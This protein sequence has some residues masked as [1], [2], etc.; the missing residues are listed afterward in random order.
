M[1]INIFDYSITGDCSNLGIGEVF[2]SI[3]GDA[4]TWTVTEISS[5]GLL[6]TSAATTDYYVN[7]LPA[8]S[9]F[10]EIIDSTIPTP[11]SL[12][13]PI[14][15]SSGTCVSIETT[16]TTCGNINGSL[17]ATTEHVYGPIDFYLYDINDNLIDSAI[18][19]TNDYVFNGLSPET[20]YV[21]ADDGGGCTGRS[22]SCI[23]YNSTP[24][25][26]GFYV[27]DNANCVSTS[28]S[29]KIYVTG[30]TGNPPFTYIWSNGET[31]S[32]IENL[33]AGNYSVTVTDNNGC[34]LT[35]TTQVLD[36]T[37]V[38]FG[39]FISTPPTCFN[40]DG[41][42]EVIIANGTAPYYYSGSNGQT[43]VTFS[44]SYIFTGLC[45]GN[46]TVFVQDSGLC[47]FTN[48]T[49][50][51]TPNSFS[52]VSVNS[53]NSTCNNNN[54]SISIVLNSG[55]PSGTFTYTLTDSL[56]GT[57]SDTT[58]SVLKTFPNLASDTYILRIK[59]AP[60]AVT[61]STQPREITL[62]R[63]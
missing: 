23:V 42:I 59:S 53:T 44:Q 7:N 43:I 19:V 1:A 58:N 3:T 18:G 24:I 39:S 16:G 48:S 49:S 20:Y 17:T 54:G 63:R 13:W 41:E 31:T 10:V 11:D 50:I 8:G 22:E 55:V 45:S 29:G 32:Y 33:I 56:G 60:L 30:L 37:P 5:S 28:G 34:I 46:F 52:I 9:Y 62:S 40:C 14:Y 26:F 36:V 27:V 57:T 4:P 21:I 15:I 12:L 6:P 38:T 47:S 35:Q 2:F 25:N 51:I 61:N